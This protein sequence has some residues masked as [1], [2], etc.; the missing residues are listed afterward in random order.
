MKEWKSHFL[1]ML[2]EEHQSQQAWERTKTKI[3]RWKQTNPVA[4][5]TTGTTPTTFDFVAR[6]YKEEPVIR[7]VAL[8]PLGFASF[9]EDFEEEINMTNLKECVL[10]EYHSYLDI[11]SER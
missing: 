4:E 10:T 3:A 9:D 11:F 2:E 5:G 8:E 7:K 1:E 6:P